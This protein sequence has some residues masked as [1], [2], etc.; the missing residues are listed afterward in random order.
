MIRK[1]TIVLLA[2][3]CALS[4]NIHA[5]PIQDLIS[6]GYVA[7]WYP[8]KYKGTQ[9]L[10]CARTCDAW[11]RSTPE[12]ERAKAVGARGT[13]LCK[14]GERGAGEI[15]PFRTHWAYGN[16]FDDRP[17]C[18]TTDQFGAAERSEDYMCLCVHESNHCPNPDLVVVEILQPAWDHPNSRSIIRAK[19]KNVGN[20]AAAANY[21]RVIDPSTLQ[22]GGA[23]YNAIA[24]TPALAPGAEAIVTFYLPYWVYNPDAHLEVTA[25]YKNVIEECDENNNTERFQALG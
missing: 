11:T 24:L 4:A 21:A 10:T 23:P 15:L 22:P 25:D 18:Y 6:N 16:Q 17:V 12:R 5:D 8:N 2:A 14:I 20:S 1:A 7:G 9:P 3:L 19:I 13:A